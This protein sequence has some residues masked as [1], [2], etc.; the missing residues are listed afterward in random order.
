LATTIVL[1]SFVA[2]SAIT[3]RPNFRH[4]STS[5]SYFA[6]PESQIPV[7]DEPL[8]DWLAA[9]EAAAR[10]GGRQLRDWQG[11]FQTRSKGFRDLV[12]DADLASQDAIRK[13]IAGQF[14]DHA[15]LGEEQWAGSLP[16]GSGQLQWIVDPLDGTTNYVHGYPNYAVSVAL[17]RGNAVLAGA[18]Y[19]PVRDQCFAAAA[20]HG[21]WCDG[22]RLSTSPVTEVAESLVA[23][24]LPPHVQRDSID[25]LDLIEA[26]HIC[27]A[28]R[29]SGSAALNLAYV[30]SG[31]LDAFWASHIHPWDV[32]AGALLIREAGGIV[33][34]RYGEAFNLW[35][36]HF[37]AAAGP[38]LHHDLLR[39]LTKAPNP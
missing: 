8:T 26:V 4:N 7:N 27:Q 1:S 6:R 35:E 5:Q 14:P 29:R 30:A 16:V 34:G 31:V 33:T 39:V 3:W 23:V 2:T 20:G 28:V 15:F 10:A 38:Q 37:L 22:A 21:A 9:A 19:D 18:I 24:S 25:L 13:L 32:A 36:P 11:R 12:T 17:A